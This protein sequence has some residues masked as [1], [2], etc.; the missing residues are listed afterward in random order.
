M[1]QRRVLLSVLHLDMMS[2]WPIIDDLQFDH[3]VK[4]VSARFIDYFLSL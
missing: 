4:A 3:L 2:E 1:L